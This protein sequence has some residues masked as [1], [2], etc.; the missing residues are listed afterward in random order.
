[1]EVLRKYL[2]DRHERR[3]DK[4]YPEFAEER[5]LG[6]ENLMREEEIIGARICNLKELGLTDRDLAPLVNQ[7]IAKPLT[8]LAKHQDLGVIE[9]VEVRAD[10]DTDDD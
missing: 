1:M 3:K 10:P 8:S 2:N 7:L 4:A 9:H 5:R 6:L